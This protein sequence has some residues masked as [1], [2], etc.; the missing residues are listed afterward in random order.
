MCQSI[1]CFSSDSLK[2]CN[3]CFSYPHSPDSMASERRLTAVG[4]EEKEA[5][6]RRKEGVMGFMSPVSC[7][8]KASPFQAQETGRVG[9]NF[10]RKQH[11]L[12][13]TQ[14]QAEQLLRTEV[15]TSYCRWPTG[16][17]LITLKPYLT[18]W[19]RHSYRQSLNIS[20]SALYYINRGK[21]IL[22]LFSQTVLHCYK[23]M[24]KSQTL[25][26]ATIK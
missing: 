14:P 22:F 9:R 17:A 21:K 8:C 20:I 10:G 18:T 2:L 13:E 12:H 11:V 15:R 7:T 1:H 25:Y 4:G 24:V 16:F 3:L 23:G 26:S 19:H 6:Y 5:G